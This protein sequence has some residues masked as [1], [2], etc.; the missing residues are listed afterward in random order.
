MISVDEMISLLKS[1]VIRQ[2]MCLTLLCSV[3]HAL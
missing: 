2:K 1:D 3:A